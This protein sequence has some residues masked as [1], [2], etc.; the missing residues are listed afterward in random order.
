MI[1]N[2]HVARLVRL[3]LPLAVL[4]TLAGTPDTAR[5]SGG[6]PQNG[7]TYGRYYE[8]FDQSGN[9]CATW[10]TC[11][12]TGWGDCDD[13]LTFSYYDDYSQLCYCDS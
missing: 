11:N 3:A 1:R 4:L 6:R 8:Y 10:E 13:D 7:C 9:L 5:G 2:R 12:N